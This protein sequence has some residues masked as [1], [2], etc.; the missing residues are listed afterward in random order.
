VKIGPALEHL[1]GSQTQLA[2][3]LRRI[4]ERHAGEVDVCHVGLQLSRRCDTLATELATFVASHGS[5]SRHH[6]GREALRSFAGRVRRSTAEA[7]GR[8]EGVG[9]LLL[10]DL[11]GLSILA[12]EAGIDWMIAHQGALAARDRDLALICR[13]GIHETERVVRWLETRIK[14]AAPQ[15]LAS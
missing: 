10:G 12:H 14:E 9:L 5:Q 6:E 11:R 3:A 13:T 8:S 4:A 1:H 7:A 15:A 2:S